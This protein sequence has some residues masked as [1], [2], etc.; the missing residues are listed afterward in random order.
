MTD[1]GRINHREDEKQ[2]QLECLA[3]MIC[4]METREDRIRYLGLYQLKHGEAAT[5]NLKKL[6]KAEWEKRK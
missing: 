6:I 5:I 1:H 3:R 4:K 2:F